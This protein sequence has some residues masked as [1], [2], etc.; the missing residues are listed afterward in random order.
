M[1]EAWRRCADGTEATPAD[2]VDLV[3]LTGRLTAWFRGLS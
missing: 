2:T 3:R 1:A